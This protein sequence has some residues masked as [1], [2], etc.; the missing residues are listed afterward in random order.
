MPKDAMIDEL[1]SLG[2]RDIITNKSLK[3]RKH[4]WLIYIQIS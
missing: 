3:K 4:L 2:F 1:F